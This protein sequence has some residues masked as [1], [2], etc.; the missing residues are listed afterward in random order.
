MFENNDSRLRA[1]I[2]RVVR[3]YLES[4]FRA[5]MLD[6][7]TSDDAYSVQCD[8]DTNP[9]QEADLGRVICRIGV[10]PPY[11]AE[12]VIVVIGKTQNSAEILLETGV[13]NA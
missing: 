4:L 3:A 12:F 2:D 7:A 5:G 13:F 8:E 10:Q 6:G 1:E 9:P 11:P